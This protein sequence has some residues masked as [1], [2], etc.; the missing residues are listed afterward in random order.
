MT[1]LL[2]PVAQAPR[3]ALLVILGGLADWESWRDGQGEELP[4]HFLQL[5]ARSDSAIAPQ[6]PGVDLSSAL[7]RAG[8]DEL[9]RWPP[10]PVSRSGASRRRWWPW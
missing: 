3:R 8:T 9:R 2:V 1:E 6:A 4:G 10:P 7:A 5:C